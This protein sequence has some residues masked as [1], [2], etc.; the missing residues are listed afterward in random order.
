MA[1]VAA[2]DARFFQHGGVDVRGVLR[3]V[4]ADA[5]SGTAGQGA[6]TLTMQLVRNAIKNDPGLTPAEGTGLPRV[7]GR[8]MS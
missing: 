5:G 3:A 4:V 7:P 2:E 1:V 8:S 6:S